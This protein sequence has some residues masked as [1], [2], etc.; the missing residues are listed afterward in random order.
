[1]TTAIATAP[2]A[3]EMAEKSVKP[4]EIALTRMQVELD[5]IDDNPFQPR[6]SYDQDAI[7]EMAEDIAELNVMQ[8]PQ[9]RIIGG[10]YELVFGHRRVRGVRHLYWT[11]RWTSWMYLDVGDFSDEDMARM[12]LSENVLR[13]DL[14]PIEVAR[15]HKR[16]IERT[17]ITED[18]LAARLQIDRTTLTNRLRILHL[19]QFVLDHV[20]S[21]ALGP[22]N[23]REFLCFVHI[24]DGQVHHAHLDDI[25][26]VV[27]RILRPGQEGAPPNWSRRYIR[28]CI[29]E[30]V[31]DNE[32]NWRPLAPREWK[33]PVSGALREPSFDVG[34]FRQDFPN[35]QHTVPA[36]EHERY[37]LSKWTF[38]KS[39]RWTCEVSEW[40]RRQT[41]ATRERNRATA[42][43]V[44]ELE[45]NLGLTD[46][47][48][49]KAQDA[50]L[51]KALANDPVW[52]SVIKGRSKT[53]PN[54]PTTDAESERLGTR[55][56]LRV[57]NDK[58]A[59]YKELK[60][61]A[62]KH[63]WEQK[64]GG[65]VP[66]W[67][68]DFEDGC[69]K[70]CASGAAYAT[71][72]SDYPLD[73]GKT[74]LCCFNQECYREKLKTG[75]R[76]FKEAVDI[77]AAEANSRDA[78]LM[79]ALANTL[80]PLPED[81]IKG[82]A[83]ALVNAENRFYTVDP[84]GDYDNRFS[85]MPIAAWEVSHLLGY[86]EARFY[87]NQARVDPGE[88][89]DA[90]NELDREG[91]SRLVAAL[92]AYHLRKAGMTEV[93]AAAISPENMPQ[94]IDPVEVPESGDTEGEASRPLAEVLAEIIEPADSDDEYLT[95]AEIKGSMPVEYRGLNS[96]KWLPAIQEIAPDAFMKK[97]R[98]GGNA[99]SAVR[100]VR[101]IIPPEEAL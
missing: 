35:H 60:Q 100:R 34:E 99:A 52:K 16:M 81:A 44:A 8:T 53:G 64:V 15:A 22:A 101:L 84:L 73:R 10:R 18:E 79:Q 45:A 19:P 55:A 46:E 41:R 6:L 74:T 27:K 86:G 96:T 42:E 67:L 69:L 33:Y 14:N 23:A 17:S 70:A 37:G 90:I 32:A 30:R 58:A 5:L 38:E 91:L 31:A 29:S 77:E 80:E 87:G 21:G 54:R 97:V 88:A 66:P 65:G 1:M 68:H 25:E 63:W 20:E 50:L 85:W 95:Y 26:H 62:Y 72:P 2:A 48:K 4:R 94:E 47:G 89:G 51:E 39:R 78:L 9:A 12:A 83:L 36:E 13:K 49:S 75:E 24:E 56:T 43:G 11:G 59:F 98:V 93:V 71:S 82:I 61:G 40:T 57:I 3:E 92:T 28:Q 76:L 7:E